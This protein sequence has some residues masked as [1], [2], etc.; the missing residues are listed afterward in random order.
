MIGVECHGLSGSIGKPFPCPAKTRDTIWFGRK[1]S[2]GVIVREVIARFEI[3]REQF[4][5]N[6]RRRPIVYARQAVMLWA[7]ALVR[8]SG[9]AI[10]YPDIAARLGGFDHTT[11]MHGVRAGRER[12][13][14]GTDRLWRL[15]M[16][17]LQAR[18]E[19]IAD[20]A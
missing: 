10:S 11:I 7:R 12:W 4:D 1:A 19:E 17:A 16:E 13:R 5:S 18:F 8:T 9:A 20:H 2:F 6:S 15:D 3:T 14:A